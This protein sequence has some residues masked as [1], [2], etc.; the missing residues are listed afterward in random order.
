[1]LIEFHFPAKLLKLSPHR[2]HHQ[3]SASKAD[4][5]MP[6]IKLPIHQLSPFLCENE[7]A[8]PEWSQAQT[9]REEASKAMPYKRYTSK[10]SRAHRQNRVIPSLHSSGN[11]LDRI[12][13]SFR[14][15]RAR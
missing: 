11:R 12:T 1:M 3:M 10:G 14:P 6:S 8:C 9:N 4:V 7:C 5:C 2:C 13:Y 15:A